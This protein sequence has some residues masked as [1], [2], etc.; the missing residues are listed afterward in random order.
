MIIALFHGENQVPSK[1]ILTNFMLN[2]KSI[3]KDK[4]HPQTICTNK[5]L[6]K[7]LT[8]PLVDGNKVMGMKCCNNNS[9][10]GM[11]MRI[12]NEDSFVWCA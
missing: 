10:E 9:N 12:G 1:R 6:G 3:W 5:L 2:F 4:C 7:T 11:D 8:A